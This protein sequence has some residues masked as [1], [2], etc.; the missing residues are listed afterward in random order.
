MLYNNDSCKWSDF[1]EKPLSINSHSLSK[2]LNQLIKDGFVEI[3]ESNYTL[4]KLGQKEYSKILK[5][6]NLDYQ[7]IL[8]EELRKVER[9]RVDLEDFFKKWN[10]DDDEIKIIFLDFFNNLEYAKIKETIASESDFH[11]LLLFFSFNNLA[12]YPEYITPQKFSKNYEISQTALDFFLQQFLKGNNFPVQIFKFNVDRE[13]TYYFRVGERIEK[14]IRLII[15]ENIKKYSFLNLLELNTSSEERK[16][17]SVNMFKNI[18]TDVSTNLF[19]K[20]LKSQLITFLPT[21]FEFLNENLKR[22]IPEN[23]DDKLKIIAFQDIVNL[24]KQEVENLKKELYQLTPLLREFPKYKVLE[25]IKKK[26][27]D[28]NFE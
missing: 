28:S 6:Y 12:R 27:E 18:I 14:M 7:S 2:N 20:S 8:E 26:F 16:E 10:I 23:L 4:S 17:H 1:L 24:S 19:N 5:I 21:Y 15:D 22:Q 9:D 13:Q 11:K 25:E 3:N